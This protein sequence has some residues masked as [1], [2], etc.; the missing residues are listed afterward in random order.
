MAIGQ[1]VDQLD[2]DRDPILLSSHASLQDRRYPQRL[3]NLFEVARTDVAILHHARATDH[4]QGFDFRKVGQKV[5]LNSVGEKG[6]LFFLA[7]IFE[8]QNRDALFGDI[9]VPSHLVR[10]RE[11]EVNKKRDS[12]GENTN[13]DEVEPAARGPA[14]RFGG[15]N[16]VGFHDSFGRDFEGPGEG[17]RDRK[18]ERE[19]DDDCPHYPVWNVEKRKNLRRYLNQKPG[20]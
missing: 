8:G 11:T 14:D 13:D 1:R 6:V 19:D 20:G 12:D 2:I 18:T 17:K 5:V 10:G 7:V 16:V 3:A 4:S 9:W 15:R